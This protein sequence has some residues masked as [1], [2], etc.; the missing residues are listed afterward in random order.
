MAGRNS[1][2]P[3]AEFRIEPPTGRQR[4]FRIRC[5]SPRTDD[6]W[7]TVKL[8]EIN[9]AND[10]Y[11]AGT[12]SKE[13]TVERLKVVLASLYASRDR[14][15]K[16]PAFMEGN[17][18]IVAALWKEK[19]PPRVRRGM[20]RPEESLRD[21]TLAAEA[22]GLH[23]LDTCDLHALADYLDTTLGD[24]PKRHARR[25]IWI[26]SILDWLGR[27]RI[28]AIT[29]R[30][31][32]EIKHLTEPEYQEVRKHIRNNDYRLLADIAFYTGLRMGEIFY[33]Q[34]RHIR[35]SSIRVEFQMLNKPGPDNHYLTD[36]PKDGNP[37]SALLLEVIRERLLIWANKPLAEKE[38]LRRKSISKVIHRACLKVNASD[39]VKNCSFHDLRHCNAI[40]LL[41]KGASIHEVAQHLGDIVSTVERFYSG[42]VLKQDSIDRLKRV[43]DG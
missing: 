19:Y 35:E 31:R 43:I 41:S 29:V 34:P 4:S 1:Y 2:H 36:T 8:P 9:A 25:V 26:N 7:T 10:L 33:L 32:A 20:K 5:K 3:Q 38:A 16:K 18:K 28:D 14:N 23:P 15:K 37:R 12:I 40:W 24:N 13:H 6:K 30:E 27:P 22:A 42:F 17:L 11:I 21:Y 39:P